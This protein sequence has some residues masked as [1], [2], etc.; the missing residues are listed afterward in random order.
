MGIST[1]KPCKYS[2]KE[3]LF[4][5]EPQ[6]VGETRNQETISTLRLCLCDPPPKPPVLLSGVGL[7]CCFE[8][9]D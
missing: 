6:M 5:G 7:V 4:L 3:Y 9:W 1:V 2:H 8:V